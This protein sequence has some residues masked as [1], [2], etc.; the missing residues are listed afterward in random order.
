MLRINTECTSYA[1]RFVLE[2]KLTRPWVDQLKECWEQAKATRP[3]D[4]CHVD[5]AAVTFIDKTG[6]TC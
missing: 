6:E 2:G 3:D 1:I 4:V 5:L